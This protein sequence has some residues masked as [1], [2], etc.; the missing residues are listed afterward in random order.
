MEG[1]KPRLIQMISLDSKYNDQL[2]E[3]FRP[4]LI[5]RI[6]L[7]FKHIN[8]LMAGFE[9]EPSEFMFSL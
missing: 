7:D 6:S 2:M 3:G 4:K 9:F 5:Q 1:F 8:Q